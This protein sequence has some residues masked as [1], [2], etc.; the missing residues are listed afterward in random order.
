MTYGDAPDPEDTFKREILKGKTPRGFKPPSQFM[1]K[2]TRN[3]NE[4]AAFRKRVAKR[5]M[6]KRKAP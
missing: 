5:I 4:T 1:V 6:K 3:E 2:F